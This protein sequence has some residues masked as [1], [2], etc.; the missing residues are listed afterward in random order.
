M[1]PSAFLENGGRHFLL[2]AVF[3]KEFKSPPTDPKAWALMGEK[4]RS[5]SVRMSALKTEVVPVSIISPHEA[6]SGS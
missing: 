3:A 1:V 4:A 6:G 2:S 5:C